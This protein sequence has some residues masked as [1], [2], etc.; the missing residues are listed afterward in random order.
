MIHTRHVQK[1]TVAWTSIVWTVCF[2]AV[3]LFPGIREAFMY[4]GLHTTTVLGEN[5]LSLT[6][7]LSGLIIWNVIAYLAVT[8]YAILFNRIRA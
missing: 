5:V 8:L 4:Y 2:A 6:T 7:F 1:V 3:A